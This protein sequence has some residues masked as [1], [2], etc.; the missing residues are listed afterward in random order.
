MIP[1]TLHPYTKKEYV[2]VYNIFFTTDMIEKV[3]THV[4]D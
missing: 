4:L 3:G 1:V 2:I